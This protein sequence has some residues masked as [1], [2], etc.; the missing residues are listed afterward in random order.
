M[1][2]GP[3][4]QA[5][6]IPKAVVAE[7]LVVR[8]LTPLMPA[9]LEKPWLPQL[10][11]SDASDVFGGGHIQVAWRDMRSYWPS[12]GARVRPTNTTTELLS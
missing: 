7:L 11:A 5:L 2:Q 4:E 8:L 3:G 10:V 6:H 9:G 12:S 1:N